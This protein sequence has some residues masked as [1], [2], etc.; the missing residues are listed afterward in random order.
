VRSFIGQNHSGGKKLGMSIII[1]V[2]KYQVII[3]ALPSSAIRFIRIET[4]DHGY[5]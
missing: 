5:A 4:M 2:S 1:D 3:D